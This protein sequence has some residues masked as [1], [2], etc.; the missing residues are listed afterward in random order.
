[1]YPR[2]KITPPTGPG[3]VRKSPVLIGLKAIYHS[4]HPK[5]AGKIKKVKTIEKL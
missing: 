5:K 2:A 1:L 4:Y 3:R